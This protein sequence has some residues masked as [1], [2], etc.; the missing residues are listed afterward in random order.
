MTDGSEPNDEFEPAPLSAADEIEVS[1]L[2]AQL[3]DP[4]LPDDVE[5]RIAAALAHD[6]ATEV[7]PAF[8]HGTTVLPTHDDEEPVHA[9]R[10]PRVLQ[11]AAALVALALIG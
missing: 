8:P 1:A 10:H 5:S 11:G 4:V 9:R 7:P 6:P 2:L 3:P